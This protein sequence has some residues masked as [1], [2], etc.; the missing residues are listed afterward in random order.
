M[1]APVLPSAVVE[2]RLVQPDQGAF[3]WCRGPGDRSVGQLIGLFGRVKT[4]GQ[5][6]ATVV[7]LKKEPARVTRETR[8]TAVPDVGHEERHISGLRDDRHDPGAVPCQ[9]LIGCTIAGRSLPALSHGAVNGR[10]FAPGMCPERWA[11]RGP[12]FSTP[13]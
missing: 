1:V 9:R 12:P 2:P 6:T 13:S 7:A 4:L 3:P 5:I 8:H 11:D 10:L